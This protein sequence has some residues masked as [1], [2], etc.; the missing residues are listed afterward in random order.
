MRVTVWLVALAVAALSATAFAA[1]PGADTARQKAQPKAKPK[2]PP[3][4]RW[5]PR[6]ATSTRSTW[7]SE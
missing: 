2:P 5:T 3:P 7:R 4:R 6:R 1:P